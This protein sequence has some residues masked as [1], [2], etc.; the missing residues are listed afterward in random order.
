MDFRGKQDVPNPREN[1]NPLSKLFFLWILPLFCE[2]AKK[3]LGIDDMY[4]APREDSA[5]VLGT[6]LGK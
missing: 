4:N 3:D 6:K 1:A 2:G 5:A